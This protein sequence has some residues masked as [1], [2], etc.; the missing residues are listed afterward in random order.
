MKQKIIYAVTILFLLTGAGG[1]QGRQE[2]EL[3]L[4]GQE[5]AFSEGISGPEETSEEAVQENPVIYV[6]VSG[7]VAKPG[8][9]ELKAGSRI[10]QAVELAG[11]IT[12]EAD[13][14]NL[15]QAGILEDGQMVYIPDAEEAAQGLP[16]EPGQED[17]RINLNTA[18]ET[19]L[20]TLPGIGA[21]KARSILAF[22]EANGSFQC[23]EDLMKIEGIKDGVFSRIKDSIRVD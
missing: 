14:K 22:R 2:E 10:F 20:M 15:N 6:Q 18:T 23:T 3:L 11:G 7:A 9:Y 12:E 1:C 8:V 21:A 19:E 16:V 4:T 17:G 5:E 13:T